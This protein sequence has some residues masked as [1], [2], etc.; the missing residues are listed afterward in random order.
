MCP[1]S[2]KVRARGHDGIYRWL[3]IDGRPLF[4]GTVAASKFYKSRIYAGSI[5]RAGPRFAKR[6]P[7]ERGKRPVR[8]IVGVPGEL[9]VDFSSPRHMITRRYAELAEAFQADHG[10]EPTTPE[11]IALH[12]RANLETRVAKHE[13]RSLAEQRQ[14]WRTQAIESSWQRTCPVRDAG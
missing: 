6:A 12:E 9:N 3:A 14:Q 8:E 5:E 13:P 11:A 4:S 7:T 1:I 2:N 10:C